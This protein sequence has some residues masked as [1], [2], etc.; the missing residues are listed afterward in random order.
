MRRSFTGAFD[1]T[2]RFAQTG[3]SRGLQGEGSTVATLGSLRVAYTGPPPAGTAPLVLLDGFLVNRRELAAA[4]E[5]PGQEPSEAL[6]ALAYRRWGPGMLAR[7]RGD[8][9]LLIWDEARGEG[10]LARDRIGMRCVYLHD[11][12]APLLRFAGEIRHLLGAMASRP[13]PD[14]VSVA[15]WVGISSR[16]GPHTL[17]QGVRR[18]EPGSMLLLDR[19]GHRVKRYW[20]PG[21]TEPAHRPRP[22]L[23]Q[24]LRA[25]LSEAVRVRLPREGHVSVL[26]S[27]GLDSASI[28]ALA[29]RA[30]SGGVLAHS[31]VFPGLAELDESALIELLRGRFGLAGASAS[32]RPGGML[33]SALEHQRAW[34]VP[35]LGW[36]DF[37]TLPLLRHA[38]EEGVAVTLGGDG[39]DELFGARADLIADQLR[40]GHPAQAVALAGRLPG[41]GAHPSR[42]Q[43][44]RI[45]ASLGIAGALGPRLHTALQR[46]AP[47]PRAPRWLTAAAGRDLLRSDDPQAWKRMRGPRW[48]AHAAHGL[49]RGIEEA[50]ILEHQRQRAAL[51]GLD[52]RLPMLD[53]D[54]IMLALCQSPRESFDPYLSRPLLREAMAGLLPDRVRLRA[55]KAWFDSLIVACL[56]GP[57]APVIR[58]LL[59]GARCESRAFIEGE[60]IALALDSLGAAR[61]VERFRAMHLI[62]R[63]LTI[64]CWLRQQLDPGGS[65]LPDTGEMSAPDI[66]LRSLPAPERA[67]TAALPSY[68][69]PP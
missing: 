57:D 67:P 15:H 42:R 19:C 18:L 58:R 54:L 38:A 40:A 37:W 27:G 17:Y 22:E 60:R 20:A 52:A 26:M 33:C 13:A 3:L 49:T 36:G 8:F 48:W 47:G 29:A 44:V 68:V 2:G 23:A 30:A 6:L 32:V 55:E 35:L 43:R 65:T 51:A 45:L 62:W 53:P 56:T 63:A 69:F 50:G 7:L 14:P 41:A 66:E 25:G 21:Y 34:E 11:G 12:A 28:A 39:G 9:S 1:P 10:L 16:P 24:E 5:S 64:E 4:L 31:G 61:G 59:M 46:I